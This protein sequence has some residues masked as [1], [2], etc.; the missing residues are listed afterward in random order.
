MVY[1]YYRFLRKEESNRKYLEEE[2]RRKGPDWVIGQSDYD[3]TDDRVSASLVYDTP[4]VPVSLVYDTPEA[5]RF[6]VF[7]TPARLVRS[8]PAVPRRR[9]APGEGGFAWVSEEE[10]EEPTTVV[11]TSGVASDA[12]SKSRGSTDEEKPRGSA[13]ASRAPSAGGRA[14]TS[15]EVVAWQEPGGWL[16]HASTMFDDRGETEEFDHYGQTPPRE[17]SGEQVRPPHAPRAAAARAPRVRVPIGHVTMTGPPRQVSAGTDARPLPAQGSKWRSWRNIFKLPSMRSVRQEAKI[18]EAGPSEAASPPRADTELRARPR[19]EPHGSPPEPA[20]PPPRSLSDGGAAG[21]K[22]QAGSSDTSAPPRKA[23][24]P[25]PPGQQ[26]RV[27]TAPPAAPG[28]GKPQAGLAAGTL[29]ADPPDDASEACSSD[30]GLSAALGGAR[31]TAADMSIQIRGGLAVGES[32]DG[33][34][35]LFP[36]LPLPLPRPLLYCSLSPR[37]AAPKQSEICV[38][39]RASAPPHSRA[40]A[41][42]GLLRP[43][44]RLCA[45]PEAARRRKWFDEMREKRAQRQRSGTPAWRAA[46]A[47]TAGAAADADPFNPKG[48]SFVHRAAPTLPGPEACPKSGGEAGPGGAPVPAADGDWSDGGGSDEGSWT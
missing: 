15:K 20:R 44:A 40:A 38:P 4:M 42:P 8:A 27:P 11:H 5:A 13:G 43:L 34:E 26:P 6:L 46:A 29:L 9:E 22:P 41:R 14:P 3:P 48:G 36:L 31:R 35:V 2:Q 12:K 23:P 47:A 10:E 16:V 45:Q 19:L 37:R 7:D 25:P 39:P 32:S 33:E 24:P 17:S 21:K 18:S 28:A 30:T 1:M